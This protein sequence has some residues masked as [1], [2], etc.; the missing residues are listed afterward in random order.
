MG[1]SGFWTVAF[2]LSKPLELFDTVFI[3]L[4]KK[5]LIF[6][7]WYHHVT[8]LLFC[9]HSYAHRSP[10]ALWFV[11]MNYRFVVCNSTRCFRAWASCPPPQTQHS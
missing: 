5:P 11:A 1:A 10:N 3:V 4:R 7:H 6:L 2:V 8:V 9:W